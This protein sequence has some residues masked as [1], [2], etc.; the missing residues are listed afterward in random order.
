MSL[1]YRW[2]RQVMGDTVGYELSS[3]GDARFSALKATLSD[4]RTIEQHYQCDV[5]GYDPGGT[6]WRIGKGR[7][8][9][10]PSTNLWL[11][12]L[13]LWEWW[14]IENPELI[15]ELSKI[16]KHTVFTDL[17][18]NSDISQARAI[19]QILNELNG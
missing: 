3:I 19:A 15:D 9:K 17:F 2:A 12:Y 4:G 13:A 1:E 18:A 7:P 16:P 10:D 11:S 5:K 8:A 14:A 6:N